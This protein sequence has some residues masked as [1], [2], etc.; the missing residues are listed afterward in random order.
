MVFF[1]RENRYVLDSSSIL[2]GRIIQLFNKKFFEGKILVP[3][4]VQAIVR[5]VIGANSDK[6]LLSLGGSFP[7]EFVAD[8]SKD[9]TEE[10]CVL[11]VA[12]KKKAKVF[13]ASDELCRHAK[14]YPMVKVIDVRDLYRA[15]T[16]IFTP[17]RLITVRILKKG[18]RANEG[19]GYIE[20]V[21]IVVENAAKYV[22]HVVNARV[23]TMISSDK[24]SLVFCSLED[25]S[26]GMTSPNHA[27]SASRRSH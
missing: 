8:K 21:K 26:T 11:N 25:G 7:V 13:T 10:V 12:Q 17:H 19:I 1:R 15:L 5:K 27:R 24:G 6:V 9:L 22:N 20:G 16:P 2:D 3:Q 23:L 14:S 4:L 18:L